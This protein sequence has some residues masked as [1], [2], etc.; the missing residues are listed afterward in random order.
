[1]IDVQ[2][3]LEALSAGNSAHGRLSGRLSAIPHACSY[4]PI[5]FPIVSHTRRHPSYLAFTITLPLLFEN[6][7]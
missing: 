7:E 1:M 5:V 4:L 2:V 6:F 3:Y